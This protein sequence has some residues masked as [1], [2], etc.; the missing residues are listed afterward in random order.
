MNNQ[1]EKIN[2]TEVLDKSTNLIW[3]TLETKQMTWQAALDYADTFD[4]WRLPAIAEL[5]TLV[6][7]LQYNP[8]IDTKYFPG[9][10]SSNYWSASPYAG[11][12]DYAW[13]A[14]FY[15]GNSDHG[16]DKYYRRYVRLVRA[17]HSLDNKEL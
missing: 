14:N 17:G 15:T 12:S 3:Q 5:L 6:D 7:Y 9:I 13:Y 4:N 10:H 16:H 11:N 8:S 1:F 2:D